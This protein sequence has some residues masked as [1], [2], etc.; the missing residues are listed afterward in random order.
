M[1]AM[2]EGAVTSG[3]GNIFSK[4]I[5]E[6]GDPVDFELPDWLNKWQPVPYTFIKRNIYLTKRIKRRLEDDGIFCSCNSEAGSSNVCGRDCLCSMLMSSCSSG[7]KCGG[8]CLNK[9]FHQRPAKKMKIVK[10]DKCGSGIVADED[11]KQGEFVIEYVGEVIDDKTCEERLWKMK[12]LGETNFYL[13]EI[14]RDTVIDATYKGN[15]SR[16][17]NH[18]CCPNTEMQKWM[19]DGETRIGIFATCDIKKGE[20]LTYDYQF[21]QFGADQDCHCGAVGCRQKLGVKPT[22]PKISSSDAALHLVACQVAATSPKV[23]TLLS[24]RQAYPNGARVAGS[25]CN[26][27]AQRVRSTRNCIGQIIR[28]SRSSDM[29]SYGIIKQFDSTTR[30]HSIMFE[31]G[32]TEYLDL[33]RE[34][35]QLCNFSV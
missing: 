14:N 31:D 33:S 7:C 21:V 20:H 3:I 23:R 16:Y 12:H 34:D 1:P 35:W 15:K 17:I 22:K 8:S 5:T 19:I 11:I 2:K 9:P 30:K 18:S 26:D 6:I 4:L 25:S 10:T 32:K 27:S 29:R 24:A 28:I 13:C